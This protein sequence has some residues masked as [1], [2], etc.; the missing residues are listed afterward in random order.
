MI[1]YLTTELKAIDF[2]AVPLILF[3]AIYIIYNIQKLLFPYIFK[4]S[5]E[6][7]FH[8]SEGVKSFNI[9]FVWMNFSN[10]N[11]EER[12]LYSLQFM[13][14]NCHEMGKN[15]LIQVKEELTK[16]VKV[17]EEIVASR[18]REELNEIMVVLAKV[19]ATLIMINKQLEK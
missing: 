18:P 15:E 14:D 12:M 16:Q 19:Q 8:I 7:A 11:W 3:V 10:E 4:R 2:I 17:G 13:Q 5:I 6:I 1:E 9:S